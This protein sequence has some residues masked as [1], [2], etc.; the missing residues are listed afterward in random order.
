M[1]TCPKCGTRVTE[2][3]SFCPNCG[4]SLKAATATVQAPAAVP[5]PTAAPSPQYERREKGEKG[6][7]GEK[8]EKSEKGEKH[9]KEGGGFFGA[10]IAGVI[11]IAIGIVS[12]IQL[13]MP[14]V[15]STLLWAVFLVIIGIVVILAFILSMARASRRN[16][17]T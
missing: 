17:P 8:R 15:N 14:N 6:E 5:T 3:M 9:E 13:S 4:A 2:A 12:V 10:I 11:L 1:P 7:K 16:P